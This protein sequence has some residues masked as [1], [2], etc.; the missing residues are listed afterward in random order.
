MHNDVFPERIWF[1][2]TLSLDLILGILVV[3]VHMLIVV[4]KSLKMEVM[5]KEIADELRSQFLLLHYSEQLSHIATKDYIY[6]LRTQL[7]PPTLL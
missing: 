7:S 3:V 2:Q 1:V 4:G 5:V 6:P